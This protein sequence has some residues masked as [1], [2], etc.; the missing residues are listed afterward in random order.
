MLAKNAVMRPCAAGEAQNTKMQSSVCSDGT[1][2]E[3]K[4]KALAAKYGIFVAM[5]SSRVRSER[6]LATPRSDHLFRNP[7][8]RGV[9]MT[10][11]PLLVQ[12]RHKPSS[13]SCSEGLSIG[14]SGVIVTAHWRSPIVGSCPG[15]Y[16]SC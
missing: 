11:V 7:I 16:E 3:A 14:R 10:D 6:A 1:G 15:K 4:I 5:K 2:L 9:K 13:R 8:G 12:Q